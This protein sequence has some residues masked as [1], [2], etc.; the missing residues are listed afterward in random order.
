[1]LHPIGGK[2][3][4]RAEL[5]I[6]DKHLFGCGLVPWAL[7]DWPRVF[8]NSFTV[9]LQAMPKDEFTAT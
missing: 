2:T 9:K 7:T 1:M 4:L 8:G 5:A 3:R 6:F